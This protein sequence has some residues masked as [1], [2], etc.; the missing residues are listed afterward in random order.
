MRI[1]RVLAAGGA[2]DHLHRR[3]VVILDEDFARFSLAA[4][5]ELFGL[6]VGL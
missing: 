3:R 6:P 5:A 1:L 2:A 4:M